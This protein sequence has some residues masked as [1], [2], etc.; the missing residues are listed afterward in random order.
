MG[1]SV[2]FKFS[3]NDAL[4]EKMKWV[5]VKVFPALVGLSKQG[6][7]EDFLRF[8]IFCFFCNP[9]FITIGNIGRASLNL[10]PKFF[11]FQGVNQLA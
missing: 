4:E 11:H 2:L 1:N 7:N 6:R 3:L 9:L 5:L 10:T 8:S